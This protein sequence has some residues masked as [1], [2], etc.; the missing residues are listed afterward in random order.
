AIDDEAAGGAMPG[1][2]NAVKLPRTYDAATGQHNPEGNPPNGAS[3]YRENIGGPTCHTVSVG[4]SLD[5]ETGNMVGPT[6]QGVTGDPGVCTTLVGE[7]TNVPSTDPTFGNCLDA[8]GNTGVT[9]KAAFHLCRTKCNGRTSV[10][11]EMVGSFKLMK[12]YP[13]KSKNKQ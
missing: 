9:I 1:N 10:G 7:D 13:D 11:V 2:Y 5:T 12:I 3:A 4:D 6:I 8:S